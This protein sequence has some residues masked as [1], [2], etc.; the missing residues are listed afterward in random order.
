MGMSK[1]ELK[2][3]IDNVIVS[4]GKGQITAD[5]LNLVL[6]NIAEN[7][8]GGGG[9]MSVYEC[10][11]AG[12]AGGWGPYSEGYYGDDEKRRQNNIEVF[13]KIFNILNEI[14]NCI[15]NEIELN[16]ELLNEYTQSIFI[17]CFWDRNLI[18]SSDY[19]LIQ[20]PQIYRLY[21]INVNNIY[22]ENGNKLR[23]FQFM[24]YNG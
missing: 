19:V 7:A 18:N 12:F 3:M 16:L 4:N 22:D 14:F 13:N 20:C 10:Y 24:G 21:S 6:N 9:I 17:R 8:G 5:A 15:E 1:E 2:E 23:A 11:R